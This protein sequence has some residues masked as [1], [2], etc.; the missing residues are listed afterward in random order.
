MMFALDGYYIF[1][2]L[3]LDIPTL[4]YVGETVFDLCDRFRQG[5]GDVVRS[6]VSLADYTRGRPQRNPGVDPMTLGSEPYLLGNLLKIA[7]QLRRVIHQES[8]WNAAACL[9]MTKSDRVVYHYSSI[10]RKPA[11]VGPAL[12][13]HRD[14]ANSYISTVGP[15][16]VRLLIPLEGMSAA[17]GGTGVVP[18]SHLI[19][20]DE[21]VA[22]EGRDEDGSSAIV[23]HLQ[24][25]QVL[26][27]HSKLVHGGGPNRSSVD[28]QLLT[29]QFGDRDARILHKSEDEELSLAGRDG[30]WLG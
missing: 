22:R 24:P 8:L 3:L 13:W 17:N 29:I 12:G 14:Y 30:P 6:S 20:D 9:L 11:I 25:G 1:T 15:H 27:I 19:S 10:I 4:A 23:P 16:F 18:G 2:G 28:R 26:G 5:D 21:A 7:P